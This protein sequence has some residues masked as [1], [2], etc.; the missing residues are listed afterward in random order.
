MLPGLKVVS[1][2]MT[3]I[4]INTPRTP[5]AKARMMDSDIIWPKR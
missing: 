4:D 1:M 3:P 5:P 2:R